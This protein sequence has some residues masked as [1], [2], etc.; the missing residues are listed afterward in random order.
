V[1]HFQWRAMILG[2]LNLRVLFCSSHAEEIDFPEVLLLD[3]AKLS[4]Y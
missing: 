3:P 4:V 2:M 1:D